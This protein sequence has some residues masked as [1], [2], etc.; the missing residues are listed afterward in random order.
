MTDSAGGLYVYQYDGNGNIASVQFPDNSIRSY[1]Y[2]ETADTGGSNFTANGIPFTSTLTGVTDEAGVRFAT[3]QYSSSGLAINAQHA[4]GVDSHTF[5]YT[6]PGATTIVTDPLGTARTYN[7]NQVV[8]YNQDSGQIQPSESG[9]GT[10]TSSETYDANGNPASVTDYNGNVT[11]YTLYD[12][13]R[14]L[15]QS[16]TEAYGT[17]QARTITTQWNSMWRQP[18]LITEPNRTTGFTYDALGNVLT[19]TITDTTVSPNVPRTWTYTYDSYGRMLTALGPRTD[20]NSTTTYTYYT[21]TTGYQCGQIQT[22]TN[23][24]G[25]V[26]TFNTYNGHGQP[27]TITDPNGVVTTLTYD[28]RQ[29]VT[30]RKVGTETTGYSYYPTG[31]LS[32]VTLP[33]GTTLQNTYDAAHRLTDITDG[34][35][36]HIHYTLDAMGNHTAEN[37]YDPSNLLRSNAHAGHQCTQSDLPGCER[38]R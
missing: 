38:S 35:G 2:N 13:T 5:N 8:S 12:M 19:K 32:T 10:A 14:N 4:G 30:S 28:A 31:L 29:R 24:V 7:F 36:N 3:F 27:L 16:R 11:Q 15:E 26:T 1:S 17:A 23:A 21:C 20:V 6:S 37:T 34:L 25:Q 22:I 33:D 9:S 18:A